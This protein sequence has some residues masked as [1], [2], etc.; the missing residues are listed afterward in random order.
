MICPPPPPPPALEA[1]EL[2]RRF[3]LDGDE[4]EGLRPKEGRRLW[5][6]DSL[7]SLSWSAPE[8]V[9][10]R[11]LLLLLLLPLLLPLALCAEV[12]AVRSDF[13]DVPPQRLLE[14]KGMVPWIGVE[15]ADRCMAFRALRIPYLGRYVSGSFP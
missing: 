15:P 5:S 8:L 14:K 10:G 3:P 13:D 12:G 7:G 6:L 11:D 2:T 9:P 4:R 1:E